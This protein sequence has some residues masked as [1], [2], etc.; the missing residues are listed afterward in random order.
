M[1][2][3]GGEEEVKPCNFLQSLVQGTAYTSLENLN[4]NAR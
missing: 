3:I 2:A 1:S 4:A